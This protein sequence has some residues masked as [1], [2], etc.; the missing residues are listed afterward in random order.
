[1]SFFV[2][3]GICMVLCLIIGVG[4]FSGRKVKNS[5]DFITGGGRAGAFLVCGSILGSLVSSQATIGT[6][7]LAFH[8][9]LSAWWFT[10]GS[11]IGCLVLGIGYVRGLRHSGCITELQIISK[12]YG[13][14]ASSMGSI[15]C[16]IGIF[17]SVLAQVV[18]CVGLVTVLFPRIP[19]PFAAIVSIGTMCIYVIFGGAWGAG[20]GGVIKLLLL[21]ATALLGILYTLITCGGISGL[22]FHW[23]RTRQTGT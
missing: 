20:M 22:L 6:A 15:L 11:G 1:M 13:T 9:G 10:L 17:I 19:I 3:L 14:A 7:Q 2:V 16:S 18:A 8:Y 12:E 5:N 21:C 4:I 23:Y